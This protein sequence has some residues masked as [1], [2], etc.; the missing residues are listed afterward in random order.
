MRAQEKSRRGARLRRFATKDLISLQLLL[1][2][3]RKPYE[4]RFWQIEKVI[5]RIDD[6]L[7]RRKS[8]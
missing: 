1:R 8:S 4:E 5:T 2:D 3:L 7:E 6:E